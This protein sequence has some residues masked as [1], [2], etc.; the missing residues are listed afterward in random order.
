MLRQAIDDYLAVRRAAG[1]SLV[2][3]E[4]HLHS[5]ERFASAR[6][7]RYVR[8]QTAIEWAALTPLSGQQA[9]RL[10]MVINFARHARAEEPRHEV[11]P[12]HVFPKEQPQTRY[13][14]VSG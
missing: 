2:A 11:P 12:R 5:F 4:G 10:A 7:D 14:P 8:K 9:H 6:G 3:H 1:F 13:P